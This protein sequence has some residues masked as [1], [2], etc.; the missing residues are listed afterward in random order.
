MKTSIKLFI[1]VVFGILALWQC[2][3]SHHFHK[4]KDIASFAIE[5]L[6][7]SISK[8]EKG[9]S[10]FTARF[11][12]SYKSNITSHNFK[13]QIR[14]ITDSLIWVSVSPGL[15][16]ELL[17]LKVT[18][19]SVFFMNRVHNQYYTGPIAAL[20]KIS[21]IDFNYKA[22]QAL[23]LNEFMVYPFGIKDTLSYLKQMQMSRIGASVELKSLS[24]SKQDTANAPLSFTKYILDSFSKRISQFEIRDGSSS[25]N[26]YLQYTSADRTLDFGTP[27]NVMVQYKERDNFTNLDLQYTRKQFDTEISAPF[28]VPDRYKQINY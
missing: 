1:I 4:P 9:F 22:L 25:K 13:G 16:V 17:R 11:S 14:I 19:D 8:S 27:D 10:N 2:S 12:A 20:K 5:E 23:L 7:D 6:Y 3:P 21:G 24:G 18:A 28:S 15:G 26:L